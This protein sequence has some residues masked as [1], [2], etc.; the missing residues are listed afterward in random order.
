MVR[1]DTVATPTTC[2][3]ALMQKTTCALTFPFANKLLIIMSVVA[4]RCQRFVCSHTSK[5]PISGIATRTTVHAQHPSSSKWRSEQSQTRHM[6]TSSRP[7]TKF[8]PLRQPQRLRGDEGRVKL[9]TRILR[10]NN[11]AD[12]K[13]ARKKVGL[14]VLP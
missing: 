5:R 3:T 2:K 9:G 6:T 10:L 4:V 8:I 12:N 7:V 14:F 11:I 13:G 1:H